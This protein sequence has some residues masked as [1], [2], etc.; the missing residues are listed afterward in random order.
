M[1]D[2]WKDESLAENMELSKVSWM[3]DFMENP[4]MDKNYRGT[5]TEETS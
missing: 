1:V 5:M 3:V 4:T 2:F